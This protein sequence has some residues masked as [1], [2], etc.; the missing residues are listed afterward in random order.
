MAG[1]LILGDSAPLLARTLF[2]CHFDSRVAADFANSGAV[3]PE[4]G[5]ESVTISSE[6]KFAGAMRVGEGGGPVWRIW[7][8]FHPDHGTLEFWFKPAFDIR[9]DRPGSLRTICALGHQQGEEFIGLRLMAK[10][11]NEVW[12]GIGGHLEPIWDGIFIDPQHFYHVALTW[13]ITADGKAAQIDLYVD[14]VRRSSVVRTLDIWPRQARLSV[15]AQVM[16]VPG[17]PGLYDELRVSDEV[18]YQGERSPVPDKPFP[19]PTEK[20]FP[21][22]TIPPVSPARTFH[23]FNPAMIYLVGGYSPGENALANPPLLYANLINATLY[24]TKAFPGRRVGLSMFFFG[25][26]RKYPKHEEAI[27]RGLKDAI[28]IA[29]GPDR[30]IFIPILSMPLDD[31][32]GWL[33]SIRQELGCHV[34][35]MDFIYWGWRSVRSRSIARVTEALLLDPAL[36]DYQ[37][38]YEDELFRKLDE[39]GMVYVPLVSGERGSPPNGRYLIDGRGNRIDWDFTD[40]EVLEWWRE[41]ITLYARFFSKYRSFVGVALDEPCVDLRSAPFYSEACRAAFRR[42]FGHEPMPFPEQEADRRGPEYLKLMR[43]ALSIMTDFNL[44]CRRVLHDAAPGSKYVTPQ[45]STRLPQGGCDHMVRFLDILCCDSYSFFDHQLVY[46]LMDSQLNDDCLDKV[47]PA[48]VTIVHPRRASWK[49]WNREGYLWLHGEPASFNKS[50]RRWTPLVENITDDI[51]FDHLDSISGVLVWPIA[52]VTSTDED[53]RL[54]EWVKRGNVLLLS[55]TRAYDFYLD[56]KINDLVL[57]A[58][59]LSAGDTLLSLEKLSLDDGRHITT[60]RTA[61]VQSLKVLNKRARI[62]ARVSDQPIGVLSPVGKGWV[63][64]AFGTSSGIDYPTNVEIDPYLCELAKEV[65]RV[66]ERPLASLSA[67]SGQLQ[68]L[69]TDSRFLHIF[70]PGGGTVTLSRR[71]SAYDPTAASSSRVMFESLDDGVLVKHYKDTALVIISPEA[72]NA[73]LR[74]IREGKGK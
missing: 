44:F 5:A 72:G 35:V 27:R 8:C 1:L 68:F 55:G 21:V 26:I 69:A 19:L 28:K 74:I 47:N 22:L 60:G 15:G 61:K 34:G 40:P 31:K 3:L 16:G 53:E 39:N 7:D 12:L 36:R 57:A 10:Q 13:Q 64:V 62:F 32:I 25:D 63:V 17:F 18:L 48:H 6:G 56:E 45:V 65:L 37:G 58:A 2:L 4:S 20:P 67:P 29:G 51:L 30:V 23:W 43:F 41:C 66:A 42:R 9:A 71:A 11:T 59:G 52:R 24:Q 33:R 14:G 50:F 46:I 73:T 54:V 49:Y 38:D 70:L